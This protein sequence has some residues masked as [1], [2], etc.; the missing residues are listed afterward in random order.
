MDIRW[1]P[2]GKRKLGADVA[3][4]LEKTAAAI[5]T[6]LQRSETIPRETGE[7][8]EFTKPDY[9]KSRQGVVSVVSS[10]PYA[11][12]LYFHPEYHFRRDRNTN[13]GGMWF[14]P[15]MNGGGKRWVEKTFAKFLRS[16]R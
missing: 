14:A 10:R 11:R 12:R 4:A 16:E 8:Q 13:A 9:S 2:Q 1:Y 15:Y 7:L 6:D 3:K 5:V